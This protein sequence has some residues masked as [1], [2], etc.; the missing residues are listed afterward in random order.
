MLYFECEKIPGE[1]S[2]KHLAKITRHIMRNNIVRIID[3][4]VVMFYRISRRFDSALYYFSFLKG[5]ATR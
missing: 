2:V 1:I 4:G 5:G 3:T